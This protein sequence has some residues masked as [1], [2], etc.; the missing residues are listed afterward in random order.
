MNR[1]HTKRQHCTFH[2]YTT[3]NNKHPRVGGQNIS[4]QIPRYASI[5]GLYFWNCL[6]RRHSRLISMNAQWRDPWTRHHLPGLSCKQIW[7]GN[8]DF[9]CVCL[10]GGC[11]CVHMYMRTHI[12]VHLC[13]FSDILSSV[14]WVGAVLPVLVETTMAV[15]MNAVVQ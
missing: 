1:P 13:M 6:K 12:C 11:M 4:L 7:G 9:T 2:K 15:I 10:S 5:S 8:T 3:Q 14:F